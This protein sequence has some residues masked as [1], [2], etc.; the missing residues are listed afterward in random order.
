MQ[1]RTAQWDSSVVF[2]DVRTDIHTVYAYIPGL[3]ELQP[4]QGLLSDLVHPDNK[5]K[6]KIK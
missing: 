6:L 3:Q 4:V 1:S 2:K 5:Q